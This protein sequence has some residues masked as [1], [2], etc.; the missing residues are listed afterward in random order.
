MGQIPITYGLP[1]ETVT[2]L[3]ML[4]SNTKIK[5]NSLDGDTDFFD[6][7]AGVL[8]GATLALYLFLICLDYA[9]QTSIDLIKEND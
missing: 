8:Q 7:V 9:L 4:I 5:V 2:A 6:V 3:V 1:K